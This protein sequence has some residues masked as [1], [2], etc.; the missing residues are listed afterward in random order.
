M[1]GVYVYWNEP[2]IVNFVAAWI[3]FVLSLLL[4]FV[5]EHKMGTPKR[6]LW[7]TGVIAVGFIW[8]AVL[9]HSQVI[10]GRTA[11]EDRKGILRQAVVESNQHSDQQ[12]RQV[13]SVV[14][15]LRDDM[16]GVKKDLEAKI[17]KTI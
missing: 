1:S 15:G 12:I 16:K 5:L 3:P 10:T 11:N 4:A 17:S 13:R 9:W 14:Q 6:I 2:K 8:S 7:R